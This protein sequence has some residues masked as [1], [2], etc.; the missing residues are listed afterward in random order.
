MTWLMQDMAKRCVVY[1]QPRR[2]SEVKL[3]SGGELRGWGEWGIEGVGGAVKGVEFYHPAW[4]HG[5]IIHSKVPP[6]HNRPC[7]PMVPAIGLSS[8]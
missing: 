1:V 4:L 2:K 7:R 8:L 3:G 5:V 6:Q